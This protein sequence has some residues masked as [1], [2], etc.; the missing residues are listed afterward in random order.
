MD[1]VQ[2]YT[3]IVLFASL[4]TE[5]STTEALLTTLQSDSEFKINV[6]NIR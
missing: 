6:A 5:L 2:R 4:E 3:I 1:Q